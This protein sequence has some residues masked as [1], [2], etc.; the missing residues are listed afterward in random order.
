MF[1]IKV[2]E[3]PKYIY[4][5]EYSTCAVYAVYVTKRDTG[6]IFKYHTLNTKTKYQLW[7][8]KRATRLC[9]QLCLK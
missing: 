7:V 4:T 1:S 2:S 9:K 8:R 5:A 6:S 3:Y